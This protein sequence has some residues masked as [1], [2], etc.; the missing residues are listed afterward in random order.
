M[1][2]APGIIM[3]IFFSEPIFLS[4]CIWARKSSRVKSSWSANLRAIFSASLRS[5]FCS[6]CSI[7]ESTSPMSRMREAMRSGWKTSKSFRPSPVEA[8]MI[9]LPVTWRTD[10]AAPPRASPSSL[11]STTP[12]KPTPSLNAWAVATA[13]WPIIASMTKSTSSGSTAARMSAAC[14]M[15][16]ASTPRRPA[17]SMMTTSWYFVL[18]SATPSRAT[19]TGS[20]VAASNS[21]ET[22][23][24]GA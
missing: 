10:S 11:V 18:A 7:R 21:E 9:G 2:W 6:A 14:C 19:C 12:V 1:P 3:S 5:Q 4:C 8:N 24:C 17:V 16:S 15:S 13:S 22:P 23:G 20:P